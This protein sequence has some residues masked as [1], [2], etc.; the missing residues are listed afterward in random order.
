[1]SLR[2]LLLLSI[3]AALC[4]G[5][6]AFS[7]VKGI[8]VG[9][10]DTAQVVEG[11]SPS[12]K[13][14]NPEG[15]ALA[16][17]PIEKGSRSIIYSKSANT[18]YV[19]HDE[20]KGEHFISAVN[21]TTNQVDKQISVPSGSVGLYLSN[22][23][24]RL[25]YFTAGQ[26]GGI[27]QYGPI[28]GSFW[29]DY[30]EPPYEPAITVIDTASNQ[31]V[32]TYDWFKS[33]RADVNIKKDWC[34]FTQ[35]IAAGDQGDLIIK[36]KA[37]RGR[38]SLVERFVVF[39]GNTPQP[40]FTIDT[41]GD[42]VGSMLSK[43][44]KLVFATVAGDKKTDGS[45]IVIDLGK[46]TSSAQTL[47]DHPTRLF[48]LGSNQDL[49]IMSGQQMLSLSETGTLSER[50]IQLNRPRKGEEGAEGE[51]STMLDGTP[52][53]TLSVGNDHAAIQ[54]VGKHKVALIDLKKQQVD[55]IIP[56][57]TAEQKTKIRTERILLAVALTAATGGEIIFIPNMGLSNEALAAN[58]D[59]RYLFA[60]DL[61][62]HEVTVV[63]VQAATIVR[64]IP[65]NNTVTK[66]QVSADG[67]HLICFGSKKGTQ[68]INLE[69]NNLEK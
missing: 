58:P 63:D 32:A 34:F 57:M 69:T 25:Y 38:D 51:T 10:G 8:E 61:E 47:P 52:G 14:T 15:V 53:E 27:R 20:K 2:K 43:D 9:N 66:L 55:A 36:S 28:P 64:R 62:V 65:V 1:M 18:L 13:V 67:K 46:G 49:W 12:V 45:V 68:Q 4:L 11:K 6:L 22:S 48:R 44:E 21:L 40:A 50:R 26:A 59:G 23:G 24:K 3:A 41:K 30:L 35:F 56:T 31:V 39:S 37:Y 5:R 60:L 29:V 19:V 16:S 42:V 17:I 54:I 7:Q 33:F